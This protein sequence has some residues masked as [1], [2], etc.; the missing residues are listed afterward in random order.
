VT[1]RSSAGGAPCTWSWKESTTFYNQITL[2][3]T[4]VS[5][6]SIKMFP[7]GAVQIAGARNLFDCCKIVKGI[8][9]IVKNLLKSD[10]PLENF[11]I[12]MINSNFSLNCNLNL[13]RVSEHFSQ[14]PVFKTEF[15]PS[16]YS[17]VK[18]KFKPAQ[19]MKE[20][21][22]SVFSTGKEEHQDVPDLL[23]SDL[24]LEN[25]RIAMINSNFSLNCNLNLIRV[26][27]HFSQSPVFK[28]EFEP[29]RY[30][31]VKI[32]FKPAQ[33]MKEVTCSVFS[34]GK[35]IITGAETLKEIAFAYN[36]IVNHINTGDT[37]RTT[38]SDEV[39]T[40]DDYLGYKAPDLVTHLREIGYHSWVH[41]TENRQI[42]NF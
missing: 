24:P 37:L 20:V 10:L 29:S 17:A 31:A 7:N 1:L 38:P 34:T 21:T 41:T 25:F 30:S 32:K 23:K 35:I 6:K 3:Y 40:F 15:E 12:A 27:E 4:D 42:K 36:V 33:D 26:S 16:R 19:D 11:R 8:R 2:T 18:I 39:E 22:C 9:W 13:I 14:S 5:K 28:T